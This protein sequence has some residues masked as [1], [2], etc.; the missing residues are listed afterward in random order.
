[1]FSAFNATEYTALDFSD[2]RQS[3]PQ[4]RDAMGVF[5]GA[6]SDSPRTL[7]LPDGL[8]KFDNLRRPKYAGCRD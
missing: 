1:M 5:M 6:I 7:G 8:I 3:V 4:M 2:K